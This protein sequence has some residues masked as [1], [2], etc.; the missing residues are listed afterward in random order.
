MS[1]ILTI[2]HKIT[3]KNSGLAAWSKSHDSGLAQ[4][5]EGTPFA[6]QL[7]AQKF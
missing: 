3:A 4:M 1:E 5:C 2:K 6:Q 7:L